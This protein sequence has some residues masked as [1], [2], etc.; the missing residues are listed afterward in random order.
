MLRGRRYSSRVIRFVLLPL[1]RFL[2]LSVSQLVRAA[3]APGVHLMTRRVETKGSFARRQVY[4]DEGLDETTFLLLVL[5]LLRPL[6]AYLA[7]GLDITSH[8]VLLFLLGRICFP[9]SKVRR[10]IALA[11]AAT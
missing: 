6:S 1:F 4:T 3:N 7:A 9:E 2:L 5:R 8:S 11:R 10:A